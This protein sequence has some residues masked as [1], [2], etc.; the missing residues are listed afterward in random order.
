VGEWT[1]WNEQP[2][3]LGAPWLDQGFERVECDKVGNGY[4]RITV[5]R[6]V[7][8]HLTALRDELRRLGG[9]L[10]S[11]GGRRSLSVGGSSTRAALSLHHTGAAFDLAVNSIGIEP[12]EDPFIVTQDGTWAHNGRPRFRVWARCDG[13]D[14]RELQAVDW[15]GRSGGYVRRQVRARCIDFTRL[16]AMH[17]FQPIPPRKAWRSGHYAREFWHWNCVAVMPVGTTW[18]DALLAAYSEAE[19]TRATGGKRGLWSAANRRKIFNG[20]GFVTP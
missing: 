6:D 3:A 13:G 16:A 2:G 4:D 12:L 9:V 1:G 10:T 11:S 8:P 7:V 19:I 20:R 5:R 18:E 17:G 14:M 15:L